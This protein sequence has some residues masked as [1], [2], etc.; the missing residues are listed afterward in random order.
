MEELR[1]SL[2]SSEGCAAASDAP[3]R[4]WHWGINGG[5]ADLPRAERLPSP[6]VGTLQEVLVGPAHR[7]DGRTN[8]AGGL[9]RSMASC[10][11]QTL[12][13]LQKAELTITPVHP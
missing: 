6:S 13:E 2:S 1:E 3:G 11:Y 9:R 5:H 12:K 10:G 7:S 4:G 8:L